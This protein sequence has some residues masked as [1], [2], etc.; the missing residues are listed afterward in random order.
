MSLRDR[1]D[2]ATAGIEAPFAVVDLAALRA[3]A[4]GLVRRAAGKPIRV[5]SKSVR[6]RALLAEVL[7]MDGFAG[8][9]AFTL[10]EAL[11]LA[12]EG[13]SDDILVAYPTTDRTALAAL[14]ADPAAARAVTLMVDAPENL[15]LIEDA[16]G[17]RRIRVCVDV[18]ASYRPL[19][20]RVRIGALRSPLHSPAQVAAFAETILRRPSLDLAGLMAYESQIAGVGDTP[21]GRPVRSRAVRAMQQRSR[22]ELARR[23]AAIVRAVRDL[24]DLEFVNGGGTGSVETTAAERSVTEVAAGSGLYQPHLFDQYSAFTGRPAALFALPVVRRPAPGVATCLGGGYHAS[25][26]PGADRLPRPYLPT[27]LSYDPYEGAGEVQTPLLGQSA[28]L[29]SIGDRVWFRHGKAGEMCERFD[30]LHLIDGDRTIE[31]VPTYRGEGH[32]FL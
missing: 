28:D 3:N 22:I 15:G 14:A 8:I 30:A 13:V 24:T 11:W 1:Y 19:G 4:A 26:P 23:R 12:R 31:T 9:M 32:A 2:T 16:A 10:P 27:G 5:A 18:D 7:A 21:P 20:G 29:L 17:G 6:C 25:G